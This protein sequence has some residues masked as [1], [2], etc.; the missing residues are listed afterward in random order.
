LSLLIS[1]PIRNQQVRIEPLIKAIQGLLREGVSIL[2]LNEDSTDD[3]LKIL[4][5]IIDS[6]QISSYEIINTKKINRI[7]SFQLTVRKAQESKFSY[8]MI[9]H[10]GWEDN[11]YEFVNIVKNKE[12]Q[13]YN[14][15]IACRSPQEFS[16]GSLY[17]FLSNRVSSIMLKTLVKETKCDSINIY[18]TEY[19]PK[20]ISSYNEENLFSFKLLSH[21]LA[22]GRVKFSDVDFGINYRSHVK[23]NTKRFFQLIFLLIS[24]KFKQKAP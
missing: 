5:Y 15:V 19:I 6:Y 12:Y 8:L 13:S 16:L 24:L 9:M 18:K 14:S 20:D 23:L 1:V 3:S 2:F 11:I 10:E 21:Y 17:N 22:L 4:D 7:N